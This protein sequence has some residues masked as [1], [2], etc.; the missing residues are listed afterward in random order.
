MDEEHKRQI[1][2]MRFGVISDFVTPL[3][4][5]RG[6][7]ERLLRDK[8]AREWQIPFS[9]RT[10]LAR[11]TILSWIQAYLAGGRRLESLM[12]QDRSDRG[13]SRVLDE[14]TAQALVRLR[15][16]MPK[17]T[18]RRLINEARERRLVDLEVPL[19]AA[20]VWRFLNRRNLVR[21]PGPAPQDRRRFEAELPNEIWQ[22]DAMHGPLVLVDGKRRKVYLFAFIDDMSR[23]I[24]HAQF[25]TS[26]QLEDYLDALRQALLTRGLPRKLYVDNG[27]AFRSLHLKEIAASLGI[28]LVH[29]PPYQPEGRGKVERWFRTVR[30]EFLP[31]FRGE[32]LQ[33]LNGALDLWI[34]EV[35]HRRP[36]RG[37]GE[38]PLRRFASNSEC[39]RPAP[40]DLE[41][42]FRKR[43]RRCVAKDRTV[44]LNGRMYEAPVELVGA[45][46]TL[47]Y[48]LHDPARVECQ[49]EGRSHGMLR[50][51]DVH[52]NCRVRRRQETVQ[53]EVE[54]RPIS[55]GRLSF[56]SQEENPA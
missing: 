15:A 38:E 43:A 13:T 54:P 52:V 18:V 25:Y 44:A 11:T 27:A 29:S 12:P 19:S 32:T 3:R 33:Q 2:I 4:L 23:L 14:D 36:H 51:V 37:T 20:T 10:R 53:L 46:V 17:A 30:T 40:R 16:E 34:R 21:P 39:L 7:R 49:R 48:H 55:G 9:D 41:D 42:H 5:D 31:G 22:S 1:A 45:P 6:E 47:L 50:P 26:E 28:A 8:C 56:A 24:L 35:Y